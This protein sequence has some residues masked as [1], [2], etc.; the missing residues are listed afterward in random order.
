MVDG[1]QSIPKPYGGSGVE[2]LM[3]DNNGSIETPWF[4]QNFDE[5][6]YKTDKHHHYVLEFPED[7]SDQIG[8]G[9]L[10]VEIE[11]DTRQE[12]GWVEYVEYLEGSKYEVTSLA[13]IGGKSWSEAEN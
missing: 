2:I 1:F 8:S 5:T 3:W 7:L 9:S 13:G 6:Y 4:G 12:D 10:V 11:V